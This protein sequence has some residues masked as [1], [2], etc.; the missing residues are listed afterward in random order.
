MCP[1]CNDTGFVTEIVEDEPFN[2][3]EKQ[4]PC[5]CNDPNDLTL[6]DI[7]LAFGYDPR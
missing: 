7:A 4:V 6:I 1:K 3:T 2:K 5:E